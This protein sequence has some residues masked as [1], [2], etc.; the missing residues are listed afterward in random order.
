MLVLVGLVALVGAVL[1]ADLAVF[2]WGSWLGLLSRWCCR[3]LR[4]CS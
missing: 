1:V 2:G 3:I 4:R